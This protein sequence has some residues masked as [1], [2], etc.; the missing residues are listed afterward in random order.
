MFL[1][2]LL[3]AESDQPFFICTQEGL[4]RSAGFCTAFAAHIISYP[5]AYNRRQ[6][7][8]QPLANGVTEYF[9]SRL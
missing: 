4:F 5:H 7:T 6:Y 1:L 9:F 3:P 8:K 2:Q